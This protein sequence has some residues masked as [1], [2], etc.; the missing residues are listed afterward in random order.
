MAKKMS[1]NTCECNWGA[2]ILALILMA[3]GLYF[4]VWGVLSQVASGVAWNWNAILMYLVGV[5]VVGLG[6]MAKY[7]ACG[8]CGSHS[9]N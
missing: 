8:G 4:L 3:F 6:K 7:K 1:K 5:L 9:C 2:G